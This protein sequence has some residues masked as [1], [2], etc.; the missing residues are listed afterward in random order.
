M[1]WEG[2]GRARENFQGRAREDFQE[3]DFWRANGVEEDGADLGGEGEG[4]EGLLE[5]G[6]H[7][8]PMHPYGGGGGGRGDEG[9]V[10]RAQ[11]LHSGMVHPGDSV[12]GLAGNGG[13]HSVRGFHQTF[14]LCCYRRF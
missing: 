6:L 2:A 8:T 7:H 4:G 3:N 14:A 12:A 9:S 5:D 13:A 11:R 10:E 1:T